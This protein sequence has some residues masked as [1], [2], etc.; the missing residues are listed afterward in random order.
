VKYAEHGYQTLKLIQNI[1]S[2]VNDRVISKDTLNK[3]EVNI[4]ENFLGVSSSF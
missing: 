3:L 1:S 4:L 2:I